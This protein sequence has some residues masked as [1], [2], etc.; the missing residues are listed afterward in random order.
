MKYSYG[1]PLLQVSFVVLTHMQST[2]K[3][4]SKGQKAKGIEQDEILKKD[5]FDFVDGG[6]SGNNAPRI[7]FK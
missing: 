1:S 3:A 7:I 5:L 2:E 4:K 6:L